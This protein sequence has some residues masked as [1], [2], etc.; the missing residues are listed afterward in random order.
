MLQYR[1]NIKGFTMSGM[2]DE[3]MRQNTEFQDR[4]SR[5]DKATK[6]KKD[7]T[8]KIMK[9]RKENQAQA[10]KGL[11]KSVEKKAGTDFQGDGTDAY[12]AA[13]DDDIAGYHRQEAGYKKHM[14]DKSTERQKKI[15]A[16]Y[17][18][19][20]KKNHKGK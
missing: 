9:V 16:G 3:Q 5:E 19:R 14:G 7:N 8:D 11:R 18:E 6:K 1:Q 2:N 13:I 12:G 15:D 20:Y 10:R 4:I 17:N